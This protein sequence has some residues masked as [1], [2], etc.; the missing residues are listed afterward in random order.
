MLVPHPPVPGASQRLL[1]QVPSQRLGGSVPPDPSPTCQEGR[2]QRHGDPRA[3]EQQQDAAGNPGRAPAGTL[4]QSP[5]AGEPEH[6]HLEG[7]PG[8]CRSRAAACAPLPPLAVQKGSQP[9]SRE[10]VREG[11]RRAPGSLGRGKGGGGGGGGWRGERR[12]SEARGGGRPGR[13]G[14]AARLLQCGFFFFF[15][16]GVVRSGLVVG[17]ST[18]ERGPGGG[19]IGTAGDRQR[20]VAALPAAH[21]CSAAAAAAGAAATA[22]GRAAAAAAARPPLLHSHLLPAQPALHSVRSHAR[23][24]AGDQGAPSASGNPLGAPGR[25]RDSGSLALGACLRRG[26]SQL[27]QTLEGGRLPRGHGS[28][29]GRRV[30]TTRSAQRLLP[31]PGGGWGGIPPLTGDAAP[32]L[33]L[34]LCSSPRK[35]ENMGR[36]ALHHRGSFPDA[37]ALGRSDK[38]SAWDGVGVRATFHSAL[39]SFGWGTTADRP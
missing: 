6:R 7:I 25:K 19:G 12:E 32:T 37:P 20:G 18:P 16:K 15:F 34:L 14:P 23:S 3:I 21:R 38:P 10:T 13:R 1:S 36:R 27:P 17:S 33:L 39:P 24:G 2:S 26:S 31:F 8:D 4:S 9:A 30:S 5:D 11:G 35:E 22:P 29:P 28:E